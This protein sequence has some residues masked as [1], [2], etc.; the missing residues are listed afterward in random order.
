MNLEK[1]EIIN[2]EDKEIEGIKVREN[3]EETP[4]QIETVSS[5][6]HTFHDRTPLRNTYKE[7][8]LSKS[9]IITNSKMKKCD[10]SNSSESSSNEI[11]SENDNSSVQEDDYE[12]SENSEEESKKEN[13]MVIKKSLKKNINEINRYNNNKITK[14]TN[15]HLNMSNNI[16]NKSNN[17]NK[18]NNQSETNTISSKNSLILKKLELFENSIEKIWK[19]IKSL[20][21]EVGKENQEEPYFHNYINEIQENHS[22]LEHP[23]ST[24]SRFIC[25]KR[26]YQ[27]ENINKEEECNNKKV[28]ISEEKDDNFYDDYKF[29]KDIYKK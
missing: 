23:V 18:I 7:K 3:E 25:I 5:R 14:E 2:L 17:N 4:S 15:I 6:R 11:E 29:T 19:D 21:K 16:Y 28:K 12:N 1:K 24:E 20:K 9:I 8:S 10:K 13:G 22:Y 27:N 26:K